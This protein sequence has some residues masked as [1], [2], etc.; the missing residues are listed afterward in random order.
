MASHG[1][2]G[3]TLTTMRSNVENEAGMGAAAA[4]GR[5]TRAARTAMT[6]IGNKANLLQNAKNLNNKGI[7]KELVKPARVLSK[8]KATTTLA[9]LT[10]NDVTAARVTRR[11]AEQKRD[12]LMEQDVSKQMEDVEM[13]DLA[14]A[15]VVKAY[16]VGNLENVDNIDKDD[17]ENP[18]LVVE[19]VNEIYEYLRQLETL[20][21]VRED[22]LNKSETKTTILPKMR[23]VLVDWLIQVHSQFNLL[24][25]TLYLTVAILDRFLQNS[26]TKIERKQLQLVGVAAMF[27][28]SKYEEMYAPEIGDFVYITDRAYT[29]SQIREMEIKILA[30]LG[31][32]LGRPLPLHFLR[33]NSKAGNVDALT[34]TLAKYAMELTLV[35]YKMAH[36]KPS[37]IAAAALALSLKVLDRMEEDKSIVEMWNSTLVH[38]TTYT[39]DAISETV[40]KLADLLLTTS[41]APASSKLMAVRKK[42]EDK[43]LSKIAMLAQL[44][45]PT[46]EKLKMGDF[47]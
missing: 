28:A 17:V 22:Y 21:G 44:S 23:A 33:R 6:D 45:G 15:P 7:K 41:K 30:A 20:Q 46:M 13:A 35:D 27:I 40:K 11:S 37:I 19:Y 34:H 32:E 18:Q 26:A 43:K 25:E 16:S 36:I 3:T 38:Y 14:A 9:Q 10:T 12:E 5:V 47:Q 31:F 2:R 29:E 24:Q 8:Q 1:I 4:K 39:F 42:Y